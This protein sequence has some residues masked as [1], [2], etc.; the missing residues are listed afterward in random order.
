LG[1]EIINP[2]NGQLVACA[3]ADVN[4]RACYVL[5][6]KRHRKAEKRSPACGSHVI[7]CPC[8]GTAFQHTAKWGDKTTVQACVMLPARCFF[9]SWTLY[10]D[11]SLHSSHEG[12]HIVCRP[13][14]SSVLGMHAS[15]V[16]GTGSERPQHLLPEPTKQQRIRAGW[17]T[18]CEVR[19]CSYSHV[20]LA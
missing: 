2:H 9:C 6:R 20:R 18:S 5:H 7:C 17:R 1:H 10:S 4:C 12:L 14:G 13:H 3:C 15:W 8:H 16:L 19:W 11:T